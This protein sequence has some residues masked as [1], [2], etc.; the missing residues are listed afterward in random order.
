M[1]YV[2]SLYER[3]FSF[4]HVLFWDY[5]YAWLEI[6]CIV[7]VLKWEF[8][9]FR[10]IIWERD[11][12]GRSKRE[13]MGRQVWHTATKLNVQHSKTRRLILRLFAVRDAI[14]WVVRLLQQNLAI[15]IIVSYITNV[16]GVKNLIIGCLYFCSLKTFYKYL[17]SLHYVRSFIHSFIVLN[18]INPLQGLRDLLDVE[19]VTWCNISYINT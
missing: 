16:D 4:I 14:I 7:I 5:G 1:S 8:L 9:L 18:S 15:L 19:L 2:F 3:S 11:I 10:R 12:R 17:F 6:L 13:N